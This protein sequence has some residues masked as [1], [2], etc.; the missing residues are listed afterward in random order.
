MAIFQDGRR[1]VFLLGDGGRDDWLC[2]VYLGGD[3]IR[4]W[5]GVSRSSVMRAWGI[6]GRGDLYPGGERV[7]FLFDPF[8]GAFQGDY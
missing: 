1:M 2:R 7:M 8:L 3:L 4:S 6:S 5:V